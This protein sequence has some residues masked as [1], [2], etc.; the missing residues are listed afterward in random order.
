ME[1][2]YRRL[3]QAGVA[4]L[5][6]YNRAAEPPNPRLVCV[7]DEYADLVSGSRRRRAAIEGLI[8]RLSAKARAA[9]IHLVCATQHASREV[10]TGVVNA[11]LMARV[12]LKVTTPINSRIAIGHP[13]A[14]TLLGA[15]DLLFRDLGDPVRLQA[16]LATDRD[17]AAVALG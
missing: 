6:T 8:S 1:T 5:G 4:D 15:G 7:C 9:G 3:E 16:P 17:V 11:N 2:R 10:I 13:G 14:A 12:A